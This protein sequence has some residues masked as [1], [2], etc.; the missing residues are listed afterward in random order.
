MVLPAAGVCPA[1]FIAIYRVFSGRVDANHRYMIDRA[2]RDA[3]VAAG[4]DAER[5]GQDLVVICA[6]A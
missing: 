5:D 4:W 3:M 2:L 1:G 6:P